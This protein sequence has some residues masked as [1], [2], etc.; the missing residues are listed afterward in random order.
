MR[1]IG[2]LL[3]LTAGATAF[4]I[5]INGFDDLISPDHAVLEDGNPV[6]VVNTS[7]GAMLGIF[8]KTLQPSTDDDSG[9]SGFSRFFLSTEEIVLEEAVV[10]KTSSAGYMATIAVSSTAY[11][12][13]T[14]IGAFSLG[15]CELADLPGYPPAFNPGTPCSHIVPLGPC[16]YAAAVSAEESNPTVVGIVTG[17]MAK[18]ACQ[19]PIP[20]AQQAAITQSAATGTFVPIL[21]TTSAR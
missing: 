14:G 11:D 1:V 16:F 4:P 21:T 20:P 7:L 15:H 10:S 12:P 13:A 6:F 9:L 19:R 17:L 8:E 3:T 5:A 2:L 18:E